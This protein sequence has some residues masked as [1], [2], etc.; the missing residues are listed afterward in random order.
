MQFSSSILVALVAS[1]FSVSAQP[2]VERMAVRP[3]CGK[4]EMCQP[5]AGSTLD[6]SFDFRYH[7]SV[8]IR[9]GDSIER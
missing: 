7:G 5:A 6:Q 3:S 1:A 8:S 9:G 2:I 4:H